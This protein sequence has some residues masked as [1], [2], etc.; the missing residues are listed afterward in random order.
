[1]HEVTATRSELLARRGRARLAEQGRDLLKDKRSALILEF[2]QHRSELLAGLARLRTLAALARGR[3]DDA[4]A[5]NGPT[6]VAGAALS[7]Q[8]GI[9]IELTA[10]SV[11]GVEVF[12][13]THGALNRTPAERGWARVLVP[14]RVH[15]AALAHERLL[16]AMLD[17]GVI[18][19]SVR[20]LASEIARTTRQISALE[21]V[22]LP[23]LLEEERFIALTL[24]ERER[25]EQGRLRRART[26][27]AA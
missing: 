2:Q 7:A 1:V 12:D 26:Q 3:L 17:V 9:Q 14:E 21:N 19:L 10:R 22:L 13:L 27:R 16:E 8:Q 6:V 4:V 15:R 18:E 11:A 25:E 23:R 20:R 5:A 24:D